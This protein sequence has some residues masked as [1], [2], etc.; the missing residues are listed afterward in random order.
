MVDPDGKP[1][2]IEMLLNGPTIERV[3]LPLPA[4]AED[5]R[6]RR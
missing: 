1:V 4:V 2:T 5:D 3:A 6:H